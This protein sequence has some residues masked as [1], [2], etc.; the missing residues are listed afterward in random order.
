MISIHQAEER[1]VRVGNVISPLTRPHL[2][3]HVYCS[4]KSCGW[5][6]TIEDADIIKS[7]PRRR[8]TGHTYICCPQCG[9]ELIDLSTDSRRSWL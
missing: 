7:G 4:S 5:R 8:T 6:G 9:E 3:Q 1:R 2:R